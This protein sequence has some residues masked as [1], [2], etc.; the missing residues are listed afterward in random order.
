MKLMKDI[1]PELQATLD[2]YNADIDALENARSLFLKN[3]LTQITNFHIGEKVYYSE[4][5]DEAG[6]ISDLRIDYDHDSPNRYFSLEL[7]VEP[8]VNKGNGRFNI[9][10]SNM[11]KYCN[12][13]KTAAGILMAKLEKLE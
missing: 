11:N 5:G 2:K 6:T 10:S 9:D 3:T 8:L 7:L 4:T 12:K 1:P 13:K